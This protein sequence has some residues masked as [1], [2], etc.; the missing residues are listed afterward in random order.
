[1]L[2]FEPG[3]VDNIRWSSLIADKLIKLMGWILKNLFHF[4]S[5]RE[6]SLFLPYMKP[7]NLF[8]ISSTC[9]HS[10][11][12]NTINWRINYVGKR[13]NSLSFSSPFRPLPLNLNCSHLSDKISQISDSPEGS[14]ACTE[15]HVQQYRPV[16][17]TNWQLL[18]FQQ[19]TQSRHPSTTPKMCT[20]YLW[21]KP[22]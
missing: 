22:T 19:N 17:H 10:Q 2:A 16:K 20:F 1:M 5:F 14:F 6:S 9:N 8:Q 7:P 12:G 13:G 3:S 4:T 21:T 11:Q 18:L 15:E